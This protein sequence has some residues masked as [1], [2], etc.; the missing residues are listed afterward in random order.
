MTVL[1]LSIIPGVVAPV[2]VPQFIAPRAMAADANPFPSIEGMVRYVAESY[3]AGSA[4]WP[5][6]AG[7]NAVTVTGTTM[8]RETTAPG[9]FG[10]AK[11]VPA[12]RGVSTTT[13][14]WPNTILNTATYT[15]ITVARY[16]PSDPT[17]ANSPSCDNAGIHSTNNV[18]KRNRIFSNATSGDSNWLHGFWACASGVN[19]RNGWYTQ[20][21]SA[22]S[23]MSGTKVDNWLLGTECGYVSGGGADCNGQYRAFGLNRTL[24]ATPPNYNRGYQ[25]VVNGGQFPLEV[26][27][28]QI[29]EVIAYPTILTLANVIKLETYLARQYGLTLSATAATKLGLYTPSVGSTLGQ[30]FT[31]QP[32]IAIQDSNGQ[33][34]TTDNTTIITAT[35]SGAN[36]SLLGTRTATAIQGVATFDDLSV[37]GT[38]GT[39]YT[40]TYTSNTSL[41]ATSESRSF[42]RASRTLI[43][44][45]SKATAAFGETAVATVTTSPSSNSDGTVTYSVASNSAC[46][47][48]AASGIVTISRPFGTCSVGASISAGTTYDA[49]T[50]ASGAITI[51]TP[52]NETDTALAITGT[53][54]G[55]VADTGTGGIFDI[56]AAITIEAWVYPTEATAGTQ[57]S[58]ITK[59]EAYQLFHIDGIWKYALW[60][61]SSWGSGISTTIPVELNEWHH[62]AITRVAATNEVNFYYDGVLAYTGTANTAAA[63]TIADSSFPFAVGGMVY[64][65]PLLQYPF[66]GRIDN[67][68]IFDIARDA[69]S[70]VSGMHSYIAPSTSGLRFYYDMNEGTGS[71]LFNRASTAVPASDLAIVGTPTFPDV[72]EA[73]VSGSYSVLKFPRSYI[74]SLGG[75]KVPT[76]IA[77]AATLV[78]GGGGGGGSRVGGGG[79]AG[80][81]LYQ[82]SISLTAGSIEAIT[83]GQGGIGGKTGNVVA[84][85]YQGVSGQNTIFGSRYTLLGGG[86]GGGYNTSVNAGHEGKS[87]GSGGGAAANLSAGAWP[88]GTGAGAATQFS[89]YGYGNGF[90]GGSGFNGTGYPGGGGGGS[91]GAAANLTSTSVAG[92]GGAATLDPILG[93]TTCYAGGGGGGVGELFSGSAGTGG[94]CAGGTSTAG[95]GTKDYLAVAGSALANSGSGGGGSGYRS[96]SNNTTDKAGG[97]GGSGIIVIKFVLVTTK[98]I[99]VGP[100]NDTTTAGL[101]ETF[102]VTGDANAPMVRSYLWQVSTDT[103]TTWATPTLGIGSTTSS[104]VTPILTTSMSGLRYQ[105][106]VIVT[107]TDTAGSRLVDTST[108]VFLIINPVLQLNGATTINKAINVAKSETYT[109]TGGTQTLRY[110]LSPTIAG[111][112]LDTSTA[113]SP[114]I[115]ISDT[116]T[117]GTF[118]ETLTVTDS[119]SASVQLPLTI[120]VGAPPSLLNTGEITQNGL[121]LNLEAGNSNSLILGD[122]TTATSQIWKDLSGN[123]INAETSGS[124]DNS[125]SCVAPTYYVENGGYLDFNGI[126]NCYRT[127]DLGMSINK[128]FTVEAWFKMK[129]TSWGG[130][131]SLFTQNWPSANNVNLVLG[132]TNGTTDIR[133]GIY[134]GGWYYS[135]T[136]FTPVQNVWTHILGTYDG[137]SMKLYAN[138]VIIDTTTTS[139]GLTGGLNN[140]GYVIGKSWGGNL[141]FKGSIGSIRVYNRALTS[142]EVAQNFN[143]TKYRFK[144]APPLLLKPTKKYGVALSESFTV[145]SGIETKTVVFSTGNRLGVIWDTQTVLNRINFKM[146][147]TLTVGAYNDTITATDSLGQSVYLPLS[148]TVTK[149]DT[150]TVLAGAATS[151]V[152]NGLQATSLPTFTISG[153][154][155]TDTAT[156]VRKYTGVDW[157]KPCSQGGGCEVGDTGP[158]G[159]TI[160]YISPTVINA[161]TGISSGGTYLEVAP[162]NWSGLSGESLTAWS[163]GTT[164]NVAGTLSAI[165]AGAENT[166]LIN[167]GLGANSVAA[168]V[169]ADLTF[170]SGGGGKSDWFLPST[171]EVKEMYEAL[172]APGLAG[173]LGITNYW[174]STQGS[175]TAQADTYWFGNGGLISPTDKLNIFAVRPIRAYSPDTITVTTVPTNAD[176]YTVTVDTVT[177]T[178]GLL[179]NYENVIFQKS[180]LDITKARQS[181][182]SVLFYGATFGVPYTITVLGGTGTGA[183][184]ESLNAGGA[185]LGCALS[186]RVLTRTSAGDCTLT[187]KKAAS[188]NY[189]LESATAVIYFLNWVINQPS[190]QVGGGATIGLNG[191]SSVTLDPNAAPMITSLSTYTAQ[192]GV[193]QIVITG[194]GFNSLD[195]ANI[196]VK[197]WRNKIAT[198]FTVNAGNTEIT[199]TVPVDATT[200]KVTVTTPKGLAVSEL[201]LAITP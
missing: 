12:V 40:I 75:W 26:S 65:G 107:D 183:V 154:L 143:A 148:F 142:T 175:N 64:G 36:G 188:R 105:Y 119:A 7:N 116:R 2:I 59:S 50:A 10:A 163:K 190:N 186:S 23:E 158:G 11:S 35:I 157:T 17:Y 28:F 73:S 137:V 122:T 162:L 99:Y 144:E 110:T 3:T 138:G 25:V 156:V 97:H 32:Q 124:F 185:A 27:D 168:K 141:W 22:I 49:A 118:Y 43:L 117:V 136:G 62:V 134:N 127:P 171:L 189:L 86:G 151:Q 63:S 44:T 19:H 123:K 126:D 184:T 166:R 78:I 8:T 77:S 182:L 195:T 161:A 93:T 47:V 34:V 13:L 46:T 153:L 152:Y 164:T 70:I 53:Q 187:I 197:F 61:S 37:M 6:T 39:S 56:R 68:A 114:V 14:L 92:N 51:S 201:S 132:G 131:V 149:A 165:G 98:P 41:T 15:F 133:I 115:R 84:N 109:V 31:T 18:D 108:A 58:V 155:S 83:I 1:A 87:G 4:T 33:T 80:A 88:A 21:A 82:P 104:Y 191:E 102:T 55:W 200:G 103:G 192:A 81:L 38:A 176:S 57:Y 30:T 150:V 128:S 174:T 199:V 177:M 140:N 71:I 100:K 181:P 79:G 173:N 179:S 66:K 196:V 95:N 106:R 96:G 9:T 125:R 60:G 90:S 113:N 72:K 89:T 198:G 172:Y 167:N 5:S 45:L 16:A 48:N 160:F 112:T 29:A 193:T 52:G 180:G 67:V 20:Q 54:Y 101:T 42:S 194:T 85:N 24:S 120:V 111:I 74:T 159:G 76:G 121:I 129:S 135:A 91:A 94:A 147:E 170:P 169:A 178:S 139:A 130:S 145:T 146:Q 69:A